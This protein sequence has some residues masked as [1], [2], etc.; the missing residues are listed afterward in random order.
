MQ[1]KRWDEHGRGRQEMKEVTDRI[2]GAKLNEIEMRVCWM[3]NYVLQDEWII[4][5]ADGP[6]AWSF[7]Y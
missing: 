6:K 2:K 3:V 5:W 4:R 7:Q 1:H